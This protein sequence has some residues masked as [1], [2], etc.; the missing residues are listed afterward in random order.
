MNNS[1]EGTRAPSS[2]GSIV[3]SKVDAM[4]AKIC[5]V[6]VIRTIP[7]GSG[8]RKTKTMLFSGDCSNVCSAIGANEIST[9]GDTSISA[10]NTVGESKEGV[11]GTSITEKPGGE[12]SRS[13]LWDGGKL[14]SPNS[15]GV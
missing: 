11:C 15:L 14:S 10:G 8:V 12:L 13:T 1:W 2:R 9:M 4:E 5:G 3:D 6:I 7:I